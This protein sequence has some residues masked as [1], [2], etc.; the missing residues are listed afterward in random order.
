MSFSFEGFDKFHSSSLMLLCQ[1]FQ[2][3]RENEFENALIYVKKIAFGMDID[4]KFC[5]KCINRKK[6]QFNENIE[7]EII[8]LL[9]KYFRIDYFLYIVDKAVTTIQSRFEHFKICEK[10][11]D[12]FI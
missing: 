11:F 5:K 4:P 1:G 12:F 8:K 10:N 3:Y 2:K 9:Q 6:K 7:N